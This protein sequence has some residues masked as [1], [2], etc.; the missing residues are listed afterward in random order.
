MRTSY[1]YIYIDIYIVLFR[2]SD[3][4]KHELKIF[5][6]AVHL[7]WMKESRHRII[8]CEQDSVKVS[9][10]GIIPTEFFTSQRNDKKRARLHNRALHASSVQWDS[11]MA[12]W[13]ENCELQNFLLSSLSLALF[14]GK[15]WVSHLSPMWDNHN[16]TAPV[17]VTLIG[18]GCLFPA[19]SGGTNHSDNTTIHT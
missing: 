5:F 8:Y 18:K 7:N 15:V 13:A 1:L 14:S 9:R 4:K 19:N 12:R 10:S 3:K 11:K 6:V 17:S 2:T 16:L